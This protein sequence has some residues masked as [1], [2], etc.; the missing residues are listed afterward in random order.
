[1]PRYLFHT[2]DGHVFHD[3][4]GRELANPA[5]AR[6]AALN[7]LSENLRDNGAFWETGSYQVTV[8]DADNLVLFT[9]EVLATMSPAMLGQAGR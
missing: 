2:Q 8:T 9:L 1:M 6:R 3:N 4:E 7:F 5:E